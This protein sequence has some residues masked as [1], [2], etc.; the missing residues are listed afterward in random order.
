MNELVENLNEK[1][2]SLTKR[3]QQASLLLAISLV[4][5]IIIFALIVP[6]N[7]ARADADKALLSAQKTY[8]ELVALA[9]K[10][11][12]AKQGVT[13][14][15]AN[16]INSEV[17]RQAARF[18]LEVQR[19]EP[20]GQNLKVWLEDSRYPSVV[21]WLGSLENAGIKSSEL[22]LEDR[23]KSGFVSVRATFTVSQ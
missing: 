11:M 7:T 16:S 9:P 15:D 4:L 10:A 20:E 2:S 3:D 8:N 1:W 18:G 23:P 13:Q 12:A 14:V 5:A 17:R 21:N 19:F 6:I 22:T